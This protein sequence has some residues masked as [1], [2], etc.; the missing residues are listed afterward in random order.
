MSKGPARSRDVG[1]PALKCCMRRIRPAFEVSVALGAFAAAEKRQM[2]LR[3]SCIVQRLET[4]SYEPS[5]FAVFMHFF[6]S[7]SKSSHV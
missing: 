1:L 6:R 3:D 2:R 5:V 7:L 4:M